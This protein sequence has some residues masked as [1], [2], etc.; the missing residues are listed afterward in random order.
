MKKR[1]IYITKYD[2]ERL[3][4]LLCVA[5]EFDYRDRGDLKNL[6][7]ELKRGKIVDSKDVPSDVV[8]M[9]SQVILLDLETSEEMTYTLVFPKDADIAS[10]RISVTAPI[11][12]AMLGYRVGSVVHWKV[13]GGLRRIKINE[14]IYQPEAAGDYHL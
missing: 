14:L 10:G 9:N 7:E 2:L 8:T 1:A 5:Q 13:P 4:E 6:E 11:G 12:T 3:G